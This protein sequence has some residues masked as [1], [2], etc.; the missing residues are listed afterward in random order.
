[1]ELKMFY[2]DPVYIVLVLPAVLFAIICQIAVKSTFNKYNKIESRSRLTGEQ[3]ARRILDS[4]GLQRVPI[5]RVSG[6]L[7]DHF[8]PVSNVLRLSDEV[9]SG[10][11][12]GAIGVAAHE[13][14]HA[15][16]Y[17]LGYSPMKLRGNIIG[18][19]N[20][21]SKLA[22]PLIF[23]GLLLEYFIHFGIV[24]A[25]IG[26]IFFALSVVFQLVTLPVEFDASNRA[27]GFLE[28]DDILERDEIGGA[29]KVLTAAAMTYVAALAVSIMQLLRLLLLV[30]GRR[31]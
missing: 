9:Y 19:T 6:K 14:G 31:R 22:I 23:A 30:S 24:F 28:S 15:V 18:V 3:A 12:I 20:I 10:R 2:I 16:Q 4:C 5:E 26:V 8:D 21:G 11:G 29:R 7:S 13:T 1:M 27:I 25:Y 17:S